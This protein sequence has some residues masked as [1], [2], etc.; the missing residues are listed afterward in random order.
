M[1]MLGGAM[2]EC[3]ADNFQGDDDLSASVTDLVQRS[4]QRRPRF[5]MLPD[6]EASPKE[7]GC[8]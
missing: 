3:L 1:G 8:M 2:W 5:P 6:I 7:N 4:K